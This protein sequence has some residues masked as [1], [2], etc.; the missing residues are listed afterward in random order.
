VPIWAR[1]SPETRLARL[2]SMGMGLF[3]AAGCGPPEAGSV[4]LP[5]GLKRP[6]PMGY[7][8]AATKG[9]SPGLGPGQFRP[10]PARQAGTKPRGG[11]AIG[12]RR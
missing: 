8:P 1:F 4:K 9:T 5:E 10:A 6:G 2:M 11:R 3:V 7:G 12:S